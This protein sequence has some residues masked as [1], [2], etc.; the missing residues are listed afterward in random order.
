MRKYLKKFFLS[1]STK[2]VIGKPVR[3]LIAIVR[4][5]RTRA[6][7]FHHN[8]LIGDMLQ[9]IDTVNLHINEIH[10]RFDELDRRFAEVNQRFE[11]VA[12]RFEEGGQQFEGIGHQINEI[13]SQVNDIRHHQ[14]AFDTDYL[15][16]LIE[17]LHYQGNLK[18]SLP[19]V[20]R[21]LVRKSL[22]SEL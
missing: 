6:M 13:N 4:L 11:E 3:M 15:P 20:L 22:E 18:K 21:R 8:T 9:Q 10:Q 7:V 2:P 1:A 19:V 16:G 17:S 5:P 12:Q 14:D